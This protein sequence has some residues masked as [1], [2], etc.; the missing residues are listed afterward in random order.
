MGALGTEVLTHLRT[1][2]AWYT[3]VNIL[4]PTLR[5]GSVYGCPIG[6]HLYLRRGKNE[7]E[8]MSP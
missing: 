1:E 5:S 7:Q 8:I 6:V 3:K 2:H 4:R